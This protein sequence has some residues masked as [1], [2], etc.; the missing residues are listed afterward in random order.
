MI[1]TIKRDNF[2]KHYN[3]LVPV[4]EK[5][6]VYC[7]VRIVSIYCYVNVRLLNV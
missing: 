3:W 5:Q 1:F 4:L 7:E 6:C 2:P